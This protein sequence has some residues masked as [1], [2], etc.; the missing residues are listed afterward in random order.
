MP[1]SVQ[2]A[3]LYPRIPRRQL[4]TECLEDGL[5]E[6]G[7]AAKR[8]ANGDL[9]EHAQ[10]IRVGCGFRESQWEK[11]RRSSC[12]LDSPRILSGGERNRPSQIPDQ[13]LESLIRQLFSQYRLTD[14]AQEQFTVTVIAVPCRVDPSRLFL[15]PLRNLLFGDGQRVLRSSADAQERTLSSIPAQPLHT[16]IVI[17]LQ[18]HP[19]SGGNVTER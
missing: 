14:H 11:L 19:K 9:P 17:S 12:C 13:V 6:S 16:Q 4:R 10:R 1:E 7:I 15:D 2:C 18:T 8:S 5:M 3:G